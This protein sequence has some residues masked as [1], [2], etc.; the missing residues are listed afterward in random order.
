MRIVVH[1]LLNLVNLIVGLQVH[2]DADVKRLVLVGEVLV[3][4]VLHEATGKLLPFLHVHIVLHEVRVKVVNDV[5]FALQIDN[6]ALVAFLIDEHNGTDTCLLSHEG[7]VGTEV[8]SDV[9]DT[10]AVLSGDI[11]TRDDAES[12]AHR[13]DGGHQ[14]L[15]LHTHEVGSLVAAHNT[16]G[17]K[18]LS[19]LIFRHLATVGNLALGS[20]IGAQTSLGQHDGDGLGGVGII[21]VDSHV[22]NLRAYAES[23]VRSQRPGRRRPSEE[24]GSP[25]PCHLRFRILHAEQGGAR[26][27]LHVAV[28]TR[29]V[30]FVRREASS[31]GRRIGLNGVALVEQSF[32]IELL[33][34]PPQRLD[35]LVIVGDVGIVQVYEI[36]HLLC[37]LAPLLRVG[38]HVLAT[39]LVVVLRRDETGRLRVV[40]VGLGN[41]QSL[42]HTQLHGQAV[43]VP[44]GLALHLE[45]LHGAVAVEGIF[46]CTA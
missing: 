28:A 22:V 30:Q 19:L 36:A 32:L 45:A 21:S 12:L 41:A 14:L 20:Q 10:C 3:V 9:H 17:H 37:Q 16:I 1:M 38:H 25:P 11:I 27:I 40:D 26:C 15:V 23:A 44:T 43:G 42:L 7:V 33:Q 8:R 18:L 24:V 35:V 13:L 2:A 34:Q 39:L 31:C 4:C 46:Q 5:V 29:L 6:R